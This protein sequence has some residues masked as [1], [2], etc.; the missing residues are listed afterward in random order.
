MSG[1][2]LDGFPTSAESHVSTL[3]VEAFKALD[4]DHCQ[5]R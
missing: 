1:E 3:D 2:Q 5:P 4:Q